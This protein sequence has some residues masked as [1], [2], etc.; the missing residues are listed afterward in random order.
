LDAEIRA[1]QIANG[2]GAGNIGDELMARAFWDRLNPCVDLEVSVLPNYQQQREAYPAFYRYTLVD[3]EAPESPAQEVNLGLLVGDTP[4]TER[5]GLYWPLQFLAS[6]LAIFHQRGITVHAV[7][8]GV[9]R[10]ESDDALEIFRESFLPI[11][12]WTV[13]S[14]QCREA[15]LSMGV[16]ADRVAVGADWGW[17]YRPRSDRSRW[18]SNVLSGL[19]LD[20]SRPLIAV[21]VLNLIWQSDDGYKRAVADALTTLARHGF[22]TFFFCNECREGDTYDAAAAKR[23]A[24]FMPAPP[25]IIPNLYYS[26]DEALALLAKARITI[27]FRYHFTLQSVLAGCVPVT[28]I[29]SQKMSGLAEELVIPLF[30]NIENLTASELV[31]LVLDAQEH[32][33]LYSSDLANRRSLMI[34]RAEGNLAFLPNLE[35]PTWRQNQRDPNTISA[36]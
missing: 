18:A 33:N 23:V 22:Q 10:L 5:E 24:E 11:R 28:I 9:D 8:V 19:G 36:L 1:F 31:R 30:S 3:F 32:W 4:V 12:S 14:A 25:P 2:L 13:R 27:S 29:R 35:A 15:L 21:N 20:L 16:A 6:R 17:L 7:G 34:R 26:P